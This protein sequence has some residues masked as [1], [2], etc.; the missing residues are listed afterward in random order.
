[1]LYHLLQ[2]A[3]YHF[4]VD[5]LIWMVPH[6]QIDPGI[7]F[8]DAPVMGKGI[9]AQSAVVASHPR[10]PDAAKPHIRICQMNDRIINAAAAKGAGIQDFV[11][12][13]LALCEQI[14]SEGFW[15]G[16]DEADAFIKIGIGHHRQDRPEYLF[17]HDRG[18]RRDVCENSGLDESP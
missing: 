2:Q 11:F 13:G 7:F 12:C 18:I 5:F 6:R 15:A 8:N 4:K 16:A 9:K 17:L 1:M 10:V 14:K 3:P